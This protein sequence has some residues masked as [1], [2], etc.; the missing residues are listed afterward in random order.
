[1]SAV[2][3]AHIDHGYQWE[4]DGDPT[5]QR[6]YRF[7]KKRYGVSSKAFKVPLSLRVL[8]RMF[9]VLPGWPMPAA[10]SHDDRVFVT[11][12]LL[13]TSGFLR[14][15]EFLSSP[16]SSRQ[17]LRGDQVFPVSEGS[18]NAV[19][20][21]IS[22]PKARW[23]LKSERVLCFGSS[24]AP[25][26]DPA[27][28]L[29]ALRLLSPVSLGPSDPAFRLAG[30]ATLTRSF[31]VS[32]TARLLSLAGIAVLDRLGAPVKVL[33]S[34][35]RAGGVQSAKEAGISDSL[36]MTLGRWSST[37][38]TNYAFCSADALVNASSDLWSAAVS[39]RPR[40]N[41][42]LVV[43][44]VRPSDFLDVRVDDLRF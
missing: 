32:R 31:M 11:A 16:G 15:G 18:G 6:A 37:A 39:P 30:G 38:W 42:V 44:E 22:S 33:A 25:E 2:R 43:G 13:A 26:A 19:C 5:V 36:I 8:L 29:A 35:W 20:V 14:G 24:M 40:S 4:L 27:G 34:S 41:D 10:M 3:S 9:A 1:M 23:W 28:W 17:V 21:L 12:S 7:I